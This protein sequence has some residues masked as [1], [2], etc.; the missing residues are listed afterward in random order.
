V[1]VVQPERKPRKPEKLGIVEYFTVKRHSRVLYLPID[2][3]TVSQHDIQK[4]DIVK[5]KLVELRKQ[6]RP[7]EPVPSGEDWDEDQ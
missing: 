5:A 7:D 1:F 2:P 6:A 4:G 3:I